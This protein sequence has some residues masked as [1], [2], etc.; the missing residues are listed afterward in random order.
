MRDQVLFVSHDSSRTGAPLLLLTLLR[1]L[2]AHTSIHF[3]ILLSQ[4]GELEREFAELGPTYLW[5][6]SGT[7]R[8]R[9]LESVLLRL[10]LRGLPSSF[11]TRDI[12]LIYSNTIANGDILEALASFNRP[13]V[14]HVHELEH[15]IHTFGSGG[16]FT[17][18]LERT[19]HFIAASSAVRTHLVQR[20][21]VP[22][23]KVD[24]APSF[25]DT[26]AWTTAPPEHLI[27]RL[28]SRLNIPLGHR[29]VGAV[30]TVD[31]RKG[32]DLFVLLAREIHHSL[33]FHDVHFVW[34]GQYDQSTYYN[35]RHDVRR[36]G[37][38]HRVHFVGGQPTPID[39]MALFDVLCLMSREEPLGLVVL[40]AA[41]LGKPAV[42][43]ADAGGAPDLV[44][45][46]GYVVP[47]LDIRQMA[48]KVIALLESP[49]ERL[50]YGRAGRQK[51]VDHYD[52]NVVAP[53]IVTI[54][55][56]LLAQGARRAPRKL[57]HEGGEESA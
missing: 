43:F 52:V 39:F 14:T 38:E 50:G 37:L 15:S 26:K 45:G 7:S 36:L 12:C 29:I 2:K 49:D 10:G 16:R 25:I 24:V 56:R 32:P 28:R 42:C 48:A 44:H 9:R 41:C 55:E 34:V 54:I 31:W 53:R 35:L 4:P 40:E 20:Y 30:G 27:A 57:R 11:S 46:C 13:I 5:T 33:G 21:R 23:S 17:R 47:Y 18:T 6:W 3:S 8:V 51:A 22:E 19:T 1:W